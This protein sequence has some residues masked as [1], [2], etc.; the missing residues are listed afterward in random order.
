MRG[1]HFFAYSLV[2]AL[3]ACGGGGGGDGSSASG[4]GGAGGGVSQP[5]PPPPQTPLVFSGVSTA[6]AISATNAGN[7]AANLITATG[8]AAGNSFGM[9]TS[10]SGVLT[11]VAIDSAQSC[12]SGTMRISGNRNND[13]TGTLSIDYNACQN[14]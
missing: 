1:R 4:G 13:G 10:G 8:G 14:A 2:L 12:D 11:G 7:I 3:T 6:A 9:Q 5:P